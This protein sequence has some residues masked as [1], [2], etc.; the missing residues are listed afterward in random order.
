MLLQGIRGTPIC[1]KSLLA[2][3]YNRGLE[4]R[5]LFQLMIH[6]GQMILPFLSNSVTKD[7]LEKANSAD[8]KGV[9]TLQLSRRRTT[10]K[11]KGPARSILVCGN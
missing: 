4:F 3:E 5:L 2:G 1:S 10:R 11:M 6:L 8:F 7:T 9:P